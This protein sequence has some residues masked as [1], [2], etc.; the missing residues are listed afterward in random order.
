MR[1]ALVWAAVIGWLAYGALSC[2]AE[3]LQLSHMLPL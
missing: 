2:A 3:V 1:G